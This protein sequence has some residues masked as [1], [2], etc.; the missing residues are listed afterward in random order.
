MYPAR[1][2]PHDTRSGATVGLRPEKLAHPDAP[3]EDLRGW[4]PA[5]ATQ[6]VADAARATAVQIFQ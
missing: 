5:A 6:V 2:R 1:A 4:W 3:D